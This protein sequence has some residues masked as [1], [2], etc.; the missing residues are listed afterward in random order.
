MKTF[1]FKK[2]KNVK[3]AFGKFLANEINSYISL[4]GQNCPFH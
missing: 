1:K 4:N 3:Y 2:E